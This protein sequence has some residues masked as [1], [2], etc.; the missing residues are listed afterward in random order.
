MAEGHEVLIHHKIDYAKIEGVLPLMIVYFWV[1]CA[2][3]LCNYSTTG[4]VHAVFVL[5]S[6]GPRVPGAP[7]GRRWGLL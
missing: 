7:V 3:I 5:P 4:K 2:Q 6:V 1:Y